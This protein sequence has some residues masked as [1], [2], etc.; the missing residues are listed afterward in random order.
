MRLED[1]S[2]EQRQELEAWGR[3]ESARL[4]A[5]TAETPGATTEP[6]LELSRLR[7]Q[8]QM[9]ERHKAQVVKQAREEGRSWHKIGQA[10]GTTAEAARQRYRQ[11]A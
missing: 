6:L 7:Y 2:P 5:G 3:A 8:Q 11:P 4:V 10:L 1:L 9:I